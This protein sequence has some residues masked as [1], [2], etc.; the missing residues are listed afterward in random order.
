M[1]FSPSH[2]SE[3][4]AQSLVGQSLEHHPTYSADFSQA[5]GRH[6]Q[7]ITTEESAGAADSA[8][9]EHIKG[10]TYE[11][12]NMSPHKYLCS[13]P[14]IKPP[15]PI[16]ETESALAK[17][18]EER[19]YHRAAAKGWELINNF[20]DTCLYFVSGWWSYSFCK[21][22]EIVQY[23]ALAAT[24]HGQVPKR[25]PN[26]QEY[27]LGQIPALP[28]SAAT[29]DWKQRKQRRQ[30]DL[31]DPA[32]PPAELQVKGDQRYLVQKLE[33]GTVCDLTGKERNIEVQYQCAPGLQYDKIGWIKEVVTCSYVMMINTPRLCKDVA[34]QP[35]VDKAANPI[36][37][38]LIVDTADTRQPL[39][40]QHAS[41]ADAQTADARETVHLGQDSKDGGKKQTQAVTIGGVVVGGKRV[42]STGDEDGGPVK[43]QQLSN[44]LVPK[45]KI[46]EV[47]VQAASKA[48]G[49]KIKELTAEELESLNID[50]KAV[51]EMREELKKLAGDSG[52]KMEVFQMNEEDEKELLGY[53]DDAKEAKAKKKKA[54]EGQREAADSTGRAKN[55]DSRIKKGVD[56]DERQEDEAV[57]S[58]EQFFNRDEL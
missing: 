45:P 26:G 1:V 50:P 49:G 17:A 11:I 12:L 28:A 54:E 42:L 56:S 5:T 14:I 2:V 32:N 58:D 36:D 4:D 3:K 48:E 53:V 27:I 35:P 18:E 40:D 52:W 47:I 22:R 21:N 25:D 43:L 39:L 57:G 33:G 31:D 34:F 16:N 13:I 20:E 41:I 10:Y 7:H 24:G 9:S 29:G 55:S 30:R 38:Q 44:L 15:G 8:G 23:H 37:C 51:D 46:L 19:E 6:A